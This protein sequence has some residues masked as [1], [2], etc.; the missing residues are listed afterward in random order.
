MFSLTVFGLSI[1]N[2]IKFWTISSSIS[3][4]ASTVKTYARETND[5]HL[6]SDNFAK[7]DSESYLEGVSQHYAPIKVATILLAIAVFATGLCVI[8]V[9]C[10]AIFVCTG[11]KITQFDSMRTSDPPGAIEVM[12]T[13]RGATSKPATQEE[14]QSGT[15]N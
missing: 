4:Q 14:G 5:V 9:F 13:P 10:V 11:G 8:L 7:F 12:V 6:C 3:H 15:F 1:S 2:M